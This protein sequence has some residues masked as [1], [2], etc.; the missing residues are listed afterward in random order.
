VSSTEAR[1]VDALCGALRT[2]LNDATVLYRHSH[3]S[4]ALDQLAKAQNELDTIRKIVEDGGREAYLA[5]AA[6]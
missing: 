5:Q 1:A 4:Q 3:Y 6:K 2:S